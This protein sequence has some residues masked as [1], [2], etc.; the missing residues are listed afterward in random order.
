VIWLAAAA[1]AVAA[2][3][4][5]AGRWFTPGREAVV[6]VAPCGPLWCGRIAQVLKP[7]PG[8]PP[9]DILNP[10][11]ALRGRPMVGVP[12]L[13]G[14]HVEDGRWRGRVYDPESGRTYRSEV[15]RA[16]AS[17]IV[18]GCWGPFCRSQTWEAAR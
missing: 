15:S 11:P 1:S 17:L 5:I 6:A 7:R 14:F 8:G 18:K 3:A 12:V 9:I 10:D 2:P 16:G 4:P 13:S